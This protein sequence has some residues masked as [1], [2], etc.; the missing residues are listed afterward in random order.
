MGTV[1]EPG[2]MRR[3]PAMTLHLRAHF[4]G[5]VLVPDQPV[6]LPINQPLEVE[7][8]ACG[9]AGLA[10]GELASSEAVSERIQR[11]DDFFRLPPLGHLPP[12]TLRR[13]NLY[14]ERA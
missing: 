7:V 12:D 8:V 4:D 5:R 6:D 1:R 2:P 13:E 3:I 9:P 14:D 10:N 11:I